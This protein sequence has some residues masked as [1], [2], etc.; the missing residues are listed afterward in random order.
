MGLK[1]ILKY[2]IYTFPVWLVLLTEGLIKFYSQEIHR[3]L[4]YVLLL[5]I[6]P[7]IYLGQSM[8]I[9]RLGGSTKGILIMNCLVCIL[10]ICL[11]LPYL[12]YWGWLLLFILIGLRIIIYKYAKI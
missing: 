1:Q 2:V 8:I 10:P 5:A 12:S 7:F 11:F 4:I 6:V 3:N 9:S